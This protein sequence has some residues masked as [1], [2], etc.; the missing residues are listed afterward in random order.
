VLEIGTGSG[1]QTALLARLAQAVYTV[2]RVAPLLDQAREALAQAGATN[3]TF[4]CRDG[5]SGWPEHAPYDAIVVGAGSPSLPRPLV[6]Q[7]ADGGRL[8]APVGGRE[9]QRLVLVTRRGSRYQ[10]QAFDPVRF[11]P[12]LGAHGWAE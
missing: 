5:T 7:L 2:E 11:V 4:D 8:L 12:L 3:V 10:E 1:Y 9:E 6:E